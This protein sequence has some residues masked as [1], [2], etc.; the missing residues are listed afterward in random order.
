MFGFFKKKLKDVVSKFSKK[1]EENLLEKDSSKTEEFIEEPSL[2]K[3]VH[4]EKKEEK[5]IKE[6]PKKEKKSK[7]KKEK[8]KKAEEKVEV[9]EEEKPKKKS[10]FKKFLKKEEVE[11][12]PSLEKDI[13]EEKEVKPVLEKKAEEEIDKVKIKEEKEELKEEIKEKKSLFKK[14]K[15]KITSK[16]ISEEKFE[17]LFSDLELVLLENN[18]AL[19]VIDKIKE[20]LRMDIV[21]VPLINVK[22][23]IENSLKESLDEIL[24]FDK[25]DLLEKVKSKKPYVIMFLGVNGTGKTLSIS[26]LCQMFKDKGLKCV[27]VAADTFRAASIEQLEEHGRKL[28]VKVIKQ[29]YGSDP[30]AVSYDGVKHAES[31]GLDVVLI[32]TAGRQHSNQN[33]IDELK[34]LN[35]VAKPDFKLFVGESI[36]GN[37][38]IFQAKS[39]NDAVG[40]DGIILSKFDVDDKGGTA[41]SISHVI[42]KPILY[43]GTGQLYSDLK[44]FNKEEILKNLG[45]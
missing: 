8:K 43:F 19:E 22:K 44:E 11:E 34:K 40:I 1:V 32:D 30:S 33:L 26:K 18:V 14:L 16:K 2:E 20:S 29:K 9:L 31:K 6:K 37:D 42:G 35:R 21:N 41:I 25:V 27:L 15:E 7:A 38:C 28:G 5:E 24:T 12:E 39:F 4:E 13:H 36:T 10:F 23:T 45:F 3:N 17:D